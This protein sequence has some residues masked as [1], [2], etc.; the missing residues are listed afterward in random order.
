[1]HYDQIKILFIILLTVSASSLLSAQQ[2]DTTIAADSVVTF[3]YVAVGD[4]AAL[5]D[6]LYSGIPEG[7]T[8]DSISGDTI[9]I[10]QSALSYIEA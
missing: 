3:D 5:A 1:M 8:I 9:P 6:S 10:I 7:F 2:P 4:T